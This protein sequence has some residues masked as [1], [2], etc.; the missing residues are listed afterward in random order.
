M[1]WLLRRVLV[2][3]LIVLVLCGT[4]AL[5]VRLNREP[6]PLQALGFDVCDGEPCF[7]GIKVGMDWSEAVNILP[8]SLTGY[9]VLVPPVSVPALEGLVI[10]PSQDGTQVEEIRHFNVARRT[11]YP[12]T[13]GA[14]V[15]LYGPPCRVF[16]NDLEGVSPRVH[17]IYPGME[18]KFDIPPLST[19]SAQPRYRV[20]LNMSAYELLIRTSNDATCKMIAP[21]F[22]RWH[23]FAS[24]DTYLARNWRVLGLR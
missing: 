24:A 11:G 18:I 13:L 21:D 23:G 15:E 20:E 19:L 16:W 10:R 14:M 1:R 12:I 9:G 2:L 5:L 6:G 4:V 3:W 17:M 22:G 7:L 8:D